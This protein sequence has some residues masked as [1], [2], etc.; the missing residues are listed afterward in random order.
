M[1][2][3][4]TG[5]GSY[6][7][8]K[9]MTNDAL[10]ERIDTS[11]EWIFKRTGICKR[12]I[13]D[14]SEHTSDLGAFAAKKALL[15][16]KCAPEDV[17]LII[18][19]TTSP[20]QTFPA[21]ATRIQDLLG[22]H[23]AAAFDIQAVCAGFVYALSIADQ[24]IKTGQAQKVLVIGAE[25]FSRLLDWT[26]RNT[27]VLFGDGA[28]ALLLEATKE[29]RGILSTYLK[30]D[31]RL[32][33]I[34]QTTGGPSLN[35][36]VGVVEMNGRD[37]YRHAVHKLSE[38]ATTV[39]AQASVTPE[40]LNWFV[41][42]QAN[43]RIIDAVANHLKMPKEKIIYTVADHANTSAASIPLALDSAKSRFQKGDLI[44]LDALGGGLA[45][46]AALIKW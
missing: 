46:G 31:G 18:C 36:K 3:Y 41:P 24:F 4:I 43:A 39:L 40:D 20:D 16:A 44:L 25:I 29:N 35:Q 38:A 28:G 8:T 21:T 23:N 2:A 12:H 14:D 34:L 30:S 7:P 27:C 17:D 33:D 15:N 5:V 32:R 37:V 9:I 45:W 10:A 19:A 1:K 13:A 22:A 42:H 6:L 26:D 11:H